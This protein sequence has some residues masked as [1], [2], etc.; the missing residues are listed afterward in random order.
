MKSSSQPPFACYRSPAVPRARWRRRRRLSLAGCGHAGRRRDTTATPTIC[1]LHELGVLA[2]CVG[3]HGNGGGVSIDHSSPQ[4]LYDSLVG[5][6]GN[7]GN[8]LV[9]SGDADASWLWVR[10]SEYSRREPDAANRRAR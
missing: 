7:S 9:V 2:G 10:M 4:A 8:D 5:V 1:D 6:S 3:C